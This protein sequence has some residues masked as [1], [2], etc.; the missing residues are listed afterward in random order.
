MTTDLSAMVDKALEFFAEYDVMTADEW[1]W[2]CVEHIITKVATFAT[3]PIFDHGNVELFN[4]FVKAAL[5]IGSPEHTEMYW[6][7]L[8]L[9]TESDPDKDGIVMLTDFS[10]MVDK[11]LASF[12]DSETSPPSASEYSTNAKLGVIEDIANRTRLA[13][14]LRFTS[15]NGKLAFLAE[16]VERRTLGRLHHKLMQAGGR[17]H[18]QLMQAGGRVHRQL[19]QAGGHVYDQLLQTLECVHQQLVQIARRAYFQLVQEEDHVRHQLHLQAAERL[20]RQLLLAAEQVFHQLVR[21]GGR[22]HRQ[23]MQAGGHVYGQLL[24]TLECAHQLLMGTF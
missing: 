3:Y 21:V 22:V 11:A 17:I 13:Q 23:L 10:A 14:L 6:F 16:Y 20:H 1:L 18:R 9:F 12:K 5:V 4:T 7:L 2:F 19:M 8:K 24:Q 15:S